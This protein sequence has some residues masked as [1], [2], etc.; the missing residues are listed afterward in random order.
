MKQYYENIFVVLVYRNTD[1][2]K[3][4]LKRTREKVKDYKVVVV[5]AYYDWNTSKK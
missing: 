1:D 4:F 3:A 2:L 5:D